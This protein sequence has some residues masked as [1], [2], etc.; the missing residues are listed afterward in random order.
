MQNSRIKYAG[1]VV[2]HFWKNLC[3][4]QQKS[5]EMSSVFNKNDWML[6]YLLTQTV[7]HQ[8]YKYVEEDKG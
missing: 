1:V 4:Q 5:I 3:K 6:M 2:G 7:W 8:I